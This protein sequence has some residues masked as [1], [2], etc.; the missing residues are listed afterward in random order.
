MNDGTEF[1]FFII[2]YNF[3]ACICILKIRSRFVSLFVISHAG[4]RQF[5]PDPDP[6]TK[7][8]IISLFFF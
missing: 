7:C 5:D 2:L 8:I 1:N 3:P 4:Y 6:D